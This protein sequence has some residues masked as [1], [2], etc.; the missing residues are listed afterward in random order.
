MISAI[1]W[2]SMLLNISEESSF[3]FHRG[4]S[5]KSRYS[6]NIFNT[7]FFVTVIAIRFEFH[8]SCAECYFNSTNLQLNN[9]SILH[10]PLLF[11]FISLTLLSLAL[12]FVCEFYLGF[13]NNFFECEMVP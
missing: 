10:H 7:N 9:T 5:L 3:H 8:F 1:F 12:N 2:G 4:A 13:G 6:N 11:A